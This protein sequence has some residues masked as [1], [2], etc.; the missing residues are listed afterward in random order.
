VKIGLALVLAAAAVVALAVP[1]TA[2]AHSRSPTIA[3]D[4]RLDVQPR[5]GVDTSVIDGNRALRLTVASGRTLLV[6]GLLGEPFLRFGPAGVWANLGSPTTAA[7]GIAPRRHGR[8]WTRVSEGRSY[9]WHDHR[10]AA[11][12]ARPA[13]TTAPFALPVFV[14][15]RAETIEGVFTYLARPAWWPWALCAAVALTAVVLLARLVPSRRRALA[16]GLAAMAGVAALVACV[17]FATGRS[18]AVASLWT[19]VVVCAVLVAAAVAGAATG[20]IRTWIASL[21]GAAAVVIC[22]SKLAVF[23]HGVVLSSLPAPATRMAVAVAFT[24]GLA[25]VG[26]SFG[27]DNDE[28]APGYRASPI[29]ET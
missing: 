16:W 10:L 1:A 15:G 28:P 19:E 7:D 4:V 13:G 23:W 29:S 5:P 9:T 11:P 12:P 17:G 14:D 2:S 8:G 26:L 25:A 24:A 22:L 3:L 18:L 20:K 6:R 27:V 21:V